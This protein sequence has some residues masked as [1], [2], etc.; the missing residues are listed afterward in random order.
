MKRK[1]RFFA[2]F[3]FS[4]F[5]IIGVSSINPGST[6]KAAADTRAVWIPYVDFDAE[7]LKDKSETDFR[8]NVN[9]MFD[10]I[11]GENLNTVYVQVRAFNDAVYP[12]N[13]FKWCDYITSNTNGPGYDPLRIM[14][15]IA[16]QKGLRFEAWMNPYRVSYSSARTAIVKSTTP[17]EQLSK[18]LEYINPSGEDCLILNPANDGAR[19]LI[20]AGV[21][22]IV[23]N[24]DV[25]GIHF[26]D[27]FYRPGSYGI[28]T[29]IERADN[30][31]VLLRSVYSKIKAIKS[32]VKFGISPAGNVAKCLEDGADVK[33]WLSSPG[34]VD[35]ICPQLYW[36][37]SYGADGKTTMYSNRLNDFVSLNKNGTDIYVGLAL[38]KV[39]EKPLSSV[40]PGW[41][42]SNQNLIK[43]VQIAESKGL[44]GYALFSSKYLSNMS[45]QEEL[46]NLNNVTNAITING[47]SP[48]Q[49]ATTVGN[50]ETITVSA[51]GGTGLL[52]QYHIYNYQTQSWSM[53]QD[54]STNANL[55]WTFNATGNYQVMCFVK[56]KIKPSGYDK[57]AYCEVNVSS[58]SPV[59]L[60]GINPSQLNTIVGNPETI[61]VNASGGT[62]LLYQF[63][64][65][66]YQTKTW[67]MVQDYSTNS[68]LNW[69]FNRIGYYQVMCFIKDKTKLSGY[70]QVA[71]CQV[72]SSAKSP[73]VLNGISPSQL[74]TIIGNP[75]TITVSASGGTGLLYQFHVYNYQTKTWSMVQDYSTNA[76]LNWAFNGTGH[77]QVMCFIK[78][79]TK[80]S[81]YDQV[82]YCEVAVSKPVVV[83]NGIN[84]SQLSTVTGKPE[85]ITV[86]AS[87][88]TGILYQYHIYN[89]Q[90]QSW[91]MAQNYSTNASLNWTFNGTGR[92]QVMCF[93]KDKT[94]LSGY[95]KVAYCEVT[96]N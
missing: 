34:Y 51:S 5:I 29:A 71:Y 86:S 88:G 94:Q 35:Y 73:V 96:V 75:E 89:Y 21:E 90:T 77:Y 6:V 16:H 22:E 18:M 53:V 45:T 74:N 54:Y 9:A 63:H 32:Y 25:D 68:S 41:T 36:S 12:S 61:T 27:Y 2:A 4:L 58:K 65:Y 50:L 7:G 24:Y 10:E 87:G 95:D 92:Y 19:S 59:V 33:T 80:L 64:V 57:V 93:I 30:V 20:V 79:N 26:D 91:S 38:Y 13:Y 40:D 43:Q 8:K 42:T 72:S 17:P 39:A 66:N 62:G 14:V 81:G 48:S 76:S 85:A 49:L 31:N 84:P 60:N 11:K 46:N 83:L 1:F 3:L 78:D 23:R 47:I 55:R 52:Y 70:D 69:T 82:A 37:D 67:S 56:D 44:K 28:T 15:E